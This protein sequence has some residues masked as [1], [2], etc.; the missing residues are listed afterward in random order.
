M[1]KALLSGWGPAI[2]VMMIIFLAS[3]TPA[4]DL[5]RF[6]VWDLVIK[7]GG[8]MTGYALLAAAYLHA[9][10]RNRTSTRAHILIAAFLVLLYAASD[11]FHQKFVP[12]R[13]SSVSDVLIDMVGALI[14]FGMV[15]LKRKKPGVRGQ[16]LE[17]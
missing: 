11:E 6:G 17:P 15:I 4:S 9:L 1:I 5:P 2:L 13:T 7:K 16:V 12:G 10:D 14:G 3:A 8:H